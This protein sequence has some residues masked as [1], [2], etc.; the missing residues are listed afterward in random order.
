MD[1][2][3]YREK[4]MEH[5]N[6][7][8]CPACGEM[9][10]MVARKCKHCGEYLIKC[11]S[12]FQETAKGF[13]ACHLCGAPPSKG[14]APILELTDV[15]ST[16][17]KPVKPESLS[18]REDPNR[19]KTLTALGINK[20]ESGTLSSSEQTHEKDFKRAIASTKSFVGSAFLA[21][22]LY[23]IGFYLIGLIVN[24]CYLSS[25]SRIKRETGVSPSGK[26]CL[27]FLLFTHFWLPLILIIFLL[28]FGAQIG[29]DLG[30]W[31]RK[32]F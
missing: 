21:W 13:D 18:P 28:V 17:D 6:S 1:G 27:S 15:V 8:Q 26:G 23:Y 24:I 12:C 9:I 10:A 16:D 5:S 4:W 11:S 30:K 22:I 32:L 20:K 2:T 31:L 3:L 29:F 19:N 14:K 25:A 7:K